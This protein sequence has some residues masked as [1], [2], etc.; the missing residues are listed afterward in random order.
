MKLTVP[1]EILAPL[2][3]SY[4]LTASA[5]MSG[6]YLNLSILA[7]GILDIHADDLFPDDIWAELQNPELPN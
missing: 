3:E 2:F 6:A 7:Q 1:G 5:P 4:K